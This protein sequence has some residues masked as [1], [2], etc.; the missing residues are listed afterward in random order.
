MADH[1]RPPGE[2]PVPALHPISV[3][4]ASLVWAVAPS[5]MA[6]GAVEAMRMAAH[7]RTEQRRKQ[8]WP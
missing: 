4:I 2:P 6:E 1:S 5:G 3:A 7:D 8:S